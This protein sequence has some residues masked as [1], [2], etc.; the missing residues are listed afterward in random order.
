VSNLGPIDPELMRRMEAMRREVGYEIGSIIDHACGGHRGFV[1]FVFSF[2][3]PEF[4]YIS[5]ANR[6]DMIKMCEEF[7]RK[8]R[9]E[10]PTTS[11]E[12]N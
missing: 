2:K 3:G 11:E 7:V 10:A 5:N 8:M 4:T 6:Q 1:L 9:N 12:R